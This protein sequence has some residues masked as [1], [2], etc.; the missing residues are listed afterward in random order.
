[1]PAK[2]FEFAVSVDHEG[3]M[4]AEEREPLEAGEAWTPEHLV[5]VAL[6]R[7][8]I[9][10]LAYHARRA[11]ISV[12]ASAAAHGLVTKRDEDGRYAFVELDCRVEVDADPLPEGDDLR[13]LLE[14]AERD[15]FVGASLTARPRYTWLVNGREVA[16]G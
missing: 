6:A 8:T 9:A 13:A 10:S 7:C 3:R 14:K 2:R 12:A 4:L 5:L 16:A 15:C 1:M 11:S